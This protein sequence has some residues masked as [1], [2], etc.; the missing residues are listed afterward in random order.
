MMAITAIAFTRL[1]TCITRS[2]CPLTLRDV[3]RPNEKEISH[4]RVVGKSDCGHSPILPPSLARNH[5]SARMHLPKFMDGR[6]FRDARIFPAH[7]QL[8]R[9]LQQ[10]L[11]K[12]QPPKRLCERE[13]QESRQ[14]IPGSSQK[15]IPRTRE[16]TR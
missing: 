6:E 16:A 15:S 1:K 4:G 3:M 10:L 2:I 7:C 13:C 8:H 5:S 11:A 9:R 14:P 12:T